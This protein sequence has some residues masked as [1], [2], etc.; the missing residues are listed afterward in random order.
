MPVQRTKSRIQ[1]T[2]SWWLILLA[3]L[4]LLPNQF[5]L[6]AK[7]LPGDPKPAKSQSIYQRYLHD[8]FSAI[9][10]SQP[11]TGTATATIL[12]SLNLAGLEV[13]TDTA[14]GR[15]RQVE[16][17]IGRFDDG[18]YIALWR[19]DQNGTDVLMQRRFNGSLTALGS[20]APLFGDGLLRL[21]TGLTSACDGRTLLAGWVDN[22]T[23]HFSAAFI[24]SLGQPY[25][26]VSV[27]LTA[28]PELIGSPAIARAFPR[29]HFAVWEEYRT[30]G[31]HIYSQEFDSIG[32][33]V[34]SNVNVDG[35]GN[36]PLRLSPAVAADTG[37]G[38]LVT[39]T[40][41]DNTRSDI[42]ARVFDNSGAAVG[43]AFAITSPAGTESFI[44]PTVAYV[45]AIDQYWLGYILADPAADSTSLYV[46]GVDRTG[47]LVG[48]A[49]PLDAYSYPWEP[50]ICRTD[51]SIIFVTT[52]YDD[53]SEVRALA[54]DTSLSVIDSSEVVNAPA[55]NTRRNAAVVASSDTVMV[56]WQDRR[57][58]E[59]DIRGRLRTDT[60]NASLDFKLNEEATGGQQTDAAM[61]AQPTGGVRVAFTDT[62][63]DGGDIAWV[64][65]SEDGT[66]TDRTRISDD[67]TASRQFDPAAAADSTGRALVVW[68]DER[69]D[70]PGPARQIAARFVTA[71]GTPDGAS[72]SVPNIMT[73]NAQ[74]QPDV[75]MTMDGN[76]AVTWIDDRSGMPRVY[77][78][79]FDATN[80]FYTPDLVPADGGTPVDVAVESE[81]DVSIDSLGRVWIAWAVQN[82]TT[83]SFHLVTQSYYFNGTLRVPAVD[84]SPIG[85]TPT[86]LEFSMHALGTGG[87]RIAWADPDTINTGIW[88]RDYDSLGTPIGPARRISD[89]GVTVHDP[90]LW[91]DEFGRYTIAWSQAGV[92]GEDIVWQRFLPNDAPTD[93]LERLSPD[94][95]ASR[96]R[97]P[98]IA[99]S[100]TF[101]YAAWHD[102]AIAGYGYNV[103]VSSIL[104]A[105][106]GVSDD[107]SF[108]PD[109]FALYANYPNPFNPET[110]I[111]FYLPT[112][113]HTEIEVF[114]VL[115]QRVRSVAMGPLPAGEHSFKWDGRDSHGVNVGSGV[116]FYRVS[117]GDY[118][119]TRK[120]L[121]L[122]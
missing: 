30:G 35:G 122:R 3:G 110:V 114:N 20:Q 102:N 59:E 47:A 2:P 9:V 78:R 56:I 70:W 116:Y 76:G 27:N 107:H 24:D 38:Y 22:V 33:R 88:L 13:S 45:P 26:T 15:Y 14:A 7:V 92:G 118:V 17:S 40:Q 86:P 101:L 25:S 74:S 21:P 115:G 12:G 41:G 85:P 51:T 108:R 4:I 80:T 105:P 32:V 16:P 103:R 111:R 37:G 60:A 68:T 57:S 109:R 62:Q 90:S 71:A 50:Q 64:A 95:A 54:V 84:L 48:S 98:V 100:Q 106:A 63:R 1:Y 36:T 49:T 69:T 53:L 82:A 29:G 10:R 96:R 6:A 99:A 97:K 66:I 11:R 55:F 19:D 81:P 8:H 112:P 23:G 119:A 61:V 113:A 121:L 72:F 77:L 18:T 94:P 117:A 87:Y 52:R 120:M 28:S 44:E 79:L 39:W 67:P 5:T 43:P 83:D 91:I 31:W 73:A 42:Y 34:G 46:R 89:S 75:A 58:G 65:V 93:T 104:Y